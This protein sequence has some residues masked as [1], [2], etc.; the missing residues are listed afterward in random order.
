L[1]DFL[2]LLKER[3]I[4]YDGGMGTLI[5]RQSPTID[6]YWGKE[7]CN[8]LLVL[9]RPGIIASIHAAYYEAG[10][11][12]V[13]TNSFGSTR[14]VLA[15]YELQ[16][17]TREL[18]I[19]AARLAKEVAAQFSTADKPRFVAGSM[20]P[21]TKDLNITATIT[22]SRLHDAYYEQAKALIEELSNRRVVDGATASGGKL[23]K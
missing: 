23:F 15:E 12:V 5:Q 22:F 20:G 1:A 14:V 6:D 7:G 10:A 3:V 19:A 2:E 21:T 17:R 4:I 8:E 16:D 18:N 11:D 13:E 9:S